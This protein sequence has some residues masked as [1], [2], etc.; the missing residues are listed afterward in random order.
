MLAWPFSSLADS[1]FVDAEDLQ[2]GHVLLGS[3]PDKV[4][5]LDIAVR[6]MALGEIYETRALRAQ[7]IHTQT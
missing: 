7:D 2:P 4:R 1:H 3:V 5:A 6:R